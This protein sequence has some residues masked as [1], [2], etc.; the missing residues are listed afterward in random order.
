MKIKPS[1]LCTDTEFIR[2]AYLDLTGLPPSP[3]EVAKQANLP[4]FDF[5]A[6]EQLQKI[7]DR[8]EREDGKRRE[9]NPRAQS[10]FKPDNKIQRG[11]KDDSYGPADCPYVE[12]PQQVEAVHERE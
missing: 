9:E 1:E 10:R 3:A 11:D 7:K 2:R 12:R 6:L 4:L 5:A 8:Q